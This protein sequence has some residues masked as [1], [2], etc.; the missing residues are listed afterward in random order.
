RDNIFVTVTARAL[1]DSIRIVA[2]AVENENITKLER[3]GADAVVAP[4]FIGGLRLAA[5]ME[6]P[7]V[8]RFID[9][10]RA[11]S[12]DPRLM[13]GIA[14]REGTRLAGCALGDSGLLDLADMIVLAARHA[15]GHHEYLPG[16]D[17]QLEP[18]MVLI[19]LVPKIAVG[20]VR[21]WALTP[22]GS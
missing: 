18:T 1:S 10:M 22:A 8:L 16:R 12:E 17:L 2:T 14:V 15:D 4:A 11:D 20:R 9:A 6:R 19:V 21:R 7:L 13:E 5:E 3:V